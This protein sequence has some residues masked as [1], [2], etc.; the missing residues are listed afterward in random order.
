MHGF[1]SWMKEKTDTNWLHCHLVNR[2][3]SVGLLLNHVFKRVNDC[4]GALKETTVAHRHL[5]LGSRYGYRL[6]NKESGT[7]RLT[8]ILLSTNSA[9][10]NQTRNMGTLRESK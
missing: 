8:T 9:A 7:V 2:S 10:S 4:T 1:M 5:Q 3:T 6:K